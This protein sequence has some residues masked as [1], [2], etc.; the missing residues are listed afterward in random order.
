MKMPFA[1]NTYDAVYA[2]EATCHAP[3]VVCALKI[4]STRFK[5]LSAFALLFATYSGISRLTWRFIVLWLKQ[6]GC[7]KEIYRV[8]KPGQHFAAY[9]WCMTDYFDASNQEHQEIKVV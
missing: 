3:D 4:Y 8:L 6:L 2:V 1:D 9:E 7:Y 5:I